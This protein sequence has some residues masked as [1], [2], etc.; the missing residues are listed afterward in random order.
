MKKT[1]RELQQELDQLDID[2]R[3]AREREVG[4]G[5]EPDL[6]GRPTRSIATAAWSRRVAAR[7]RQRVQLRPIIHARGG[8]DECM[9]DVRQFG[10]VAL[11]G[12][13]ATQLV[14]D[15]LA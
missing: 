12:R 11:G 6:S 4:S 14:G 2:I 9:F 1:L 3:L 7:K 13:V 15:Y 10:D 5:T 8:S